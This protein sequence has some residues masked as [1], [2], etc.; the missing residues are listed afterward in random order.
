[1]SKGKRRERGSQSGKPSGLVFEG[2]IWEGLGSATLL[3]E[4]HHWRLASG[5][6]QPMPFPVCSLPRAVDER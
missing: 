1:M 2:T 6:R 4:V 3:E 5:F